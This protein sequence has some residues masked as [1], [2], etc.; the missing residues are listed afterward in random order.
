MRGHLGALASKVNFKICSLK[1][2]LAEYEELK[3]VID[4]VSKEKEMLQQKKERLQHERERLQHEQH[5]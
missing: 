3:H 5:G 2:V 1:D 4:G